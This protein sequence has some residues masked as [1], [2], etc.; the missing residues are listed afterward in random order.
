MR[1][2]VAAYIQAIDNDQRPLFDRV[3]RLVMEVQP[4][5]QVV[6]SYRMPTYVVGTR[7]LHVGV[8]KHGLSFYGWEHG[9]GCGLVAGN[10]HL[11]SGR[12]TL[13]LPITEAA[14]ISATSCVP[15]WMPFSPSEQALVLLRRRHHVRWHLGRITLGV[16]SCTASL[17]SA[18]AACNA[19]TTSSACTAT[20][21]PCAPAPS[22]MVRPTIRSSAT[23]GHG[24]ALPNG[25]MVPRS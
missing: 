19:S 21:T 13:R 23:T 7:R 10:P 6:I 22:V 14:H 17:M 20:A 25:V 12:G 5:A 2:D 8:W 16:Q 24:R 4:A 18:T 3:H 1:A 11:D 15:S 9:R